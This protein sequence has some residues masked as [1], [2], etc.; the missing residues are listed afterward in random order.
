MIAENFV[1]FVHG[2][3]PDLLDSSGR[4]LYSAFRTMQAGNLYILGINPGG[5]PVTLAANT[6]RANLTALPGCT[7]N[8]YIDENWGKKGPG[9]GKVQ[10]RLRYIVESILGEKLADVCA[11]NL[12]FVRSK[13]SESVKDVAFA[14]KC[15]IVHRQI[16]KLVR[17][18]IIL[19]LGNG[20]GT[21]Y[22]YIRRFA[23]DPAQSCSAED[24]RLSGYSNWRCKSFD[25]TI[26]GRVT[27]VIGLPHPSFYLMEGKVDAISWLREKA[28]RAT[29]LSS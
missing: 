24:S 19:S 16:L 5:D 14:H 11:S 29:A 3:I 27:R 12:V 20:P 25:A 13:R 18:K 26:D 8:A 7:E 21:A 15:W 6:I 17:A 2:A 10:R 1:E 23:H 9:N 28:E 4:V 22:Q